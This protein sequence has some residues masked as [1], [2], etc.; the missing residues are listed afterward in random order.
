MP[1]KRI[2]KKP[3]W[4]INNNK[5][6]PLIIKHTKYINNEITKENKA[7]SEL[8]NSYKVYDLFFSKINTF[9]KALIIHVSF[10]FIYSYL[11]TKILYDA[12]NSEGFSFYR[13]SFTQASGIFITISFFIL[14]ISLASFI[15][16]YSVNRKNNLSKFYI[17]FGQNIFFSMIASLLFAIFVTICNVGIINGMILIFII[18]IIY[19]SCSILGM[20]DNKNHYDQNLLNMLILIVSIFVLISLFF[21]LF[22][23]NITHLFT[24]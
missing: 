10:I 11:I 19:I 1:R 22:G 17:S 8:S 4:Q 24:V 3:K 7:T 16:L 18:L 5:K 14:V 9:N 2:H 13:L 15:I 21:G 6:H 23:S 12:I 20:D